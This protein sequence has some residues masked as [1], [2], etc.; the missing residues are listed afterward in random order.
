MKYL[1]H[2]HFFKV[3]TVKQIQVSS[4][5]EIVYVALR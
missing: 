1:K 2:T 3:D 5:L 4:I